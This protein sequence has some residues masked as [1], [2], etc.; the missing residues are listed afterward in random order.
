MV[1]DG[2]DPLVNTV[3]ATF[4]DGMDFTETEFDDHTVELFQP[5]ITLDLTADGLSKIGD[6]I[7][8]TILVEN[9]SSGDTPNLIGTVV[10]PYDGSET[11]INLASGETYTVSPSLKVPVTRL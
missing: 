6:D 7:E 5:S 11:A 1:P 8:Y 3:T 10:D 9:T 2:A 4:T